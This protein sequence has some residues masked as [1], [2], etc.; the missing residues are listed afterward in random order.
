MSSAPL[1]LGIV[2][3]FAR[4]GGTLLNQC[5]GCHPSNAVLS[6]VNP[7]G[8]YLA[9]LWQAEHWLGLVNDQN[10]AKLAALP[11]EGQIARLATLA[12]ASGRRLIVRD[13]SAL[14][15]L[16]GVM[17]GVEPSGVL[18]QEA[19]LPRAGLELRRVVLSRR[20]NGIF[21][22]LRAR[23]P[24][25]LRLDHETF[26]KAYLAY[27]QSVCHYPVVHLKEFTLDPK[28]WMRRICAELGAAYEEDFQAR[29]AQYR[30]C[31]GNTTLDVAPFSS[32]RRAI[33]PV[34][35]P[36]GRPPHPL[37]LEA[38]RLLGYDRT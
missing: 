16:A 20:A 32:T 28:P 26:G 9:P 7:A 1:P 10:R 27:A 4:S 22:S 35:P 38:D 18:E 14:N 11:Y 17:K 37:F 33:A 25:F 15:F 31:T 30:N 21:H 5:L 19:Y 29:F 23:I 8:S 2:Y 34:L 24:Q 13:W 3:C 6:E 12:A 36:E